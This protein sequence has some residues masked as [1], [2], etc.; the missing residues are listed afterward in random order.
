MKIEKFNCPISVVAYNRPEYLAQCLQFLD[1]S[2]DIKLYDVPVF[3][4]CDGGEQSTLKENIR[5]AKK[6]SFIKDIIYQ[7]KNLNLPYHLNFIY[8]TMFH[9]LN[10]N[11]FIYLEEDVVVSS[12]YYRTMNRAYDFYN[13]KEEG[14]VA[15]NS[16]IWCNL[17]DEQ[18]EI[19]RFK[20]SNNNSSTCN[21]LLTRRGYDMM[22]PILIEYLERFV[23]NNDYKKMDHK[24]I[25][26]WAKDK[27]FNSIYNIHPLIKENV[28]SSV[29]SILNM[30][31]R[32]NGG[33][34]LSSVINRVRYIGKYGLHGNEN[35]WNKYEFDK[36]NLI[37]FSSDE[38]NYIFI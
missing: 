19:Y 7:S 10:Y 16:G 29:D 23:K 6:Y 12:Y 5:L 38:D 15:I 25:I 2:P 3:L 30:A 18:K 4:F 24:S 17:S 26:K 21:L 34:H 28:T 36:M 11:K 22:Y 37:N 9:E 32:I 20:F 14:L 33:Y 13:K 31:R 8:N 35:W 1:F 27:Y